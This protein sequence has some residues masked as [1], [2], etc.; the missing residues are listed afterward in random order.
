MVDG[1]HGMQ[2]RVETADGRRQFACFPAAVLGL[3]VDQVDRFLLLSRPDRGAWQV[4][5]GALEA[6]ESPRDALIRETAEEVG[7]GVRIQPIAVA[8]T[9]QYPYD[10]SVP[11][12]LSIAYVAR[13]GGGA[14]EP[15]SDMVGSEAGWFTLEEISDERTHLLMPELPWLCRRALTLTN[16]YSTPAEEELEPWVTR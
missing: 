7:A 16:A 2:H 13:Y 8:H 14:I 9:F 5:A 3:I 15:G 6:G 4:V 12:I 11:P 1:G 10:P